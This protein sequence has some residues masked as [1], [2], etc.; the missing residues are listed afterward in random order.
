MTTGVDRGAAAGAV[1]AQAPEL[2]L[3]DRRAFVGFPPIIF[4]P[5]V[6]IADFA[7]Q[8]PEVTFPFSVTG[9]AL[10]YQRRKLHFGFLEVLIDAEVISR[11]VAQL[12]AKLLEL[13]EVKLHFRAGYL[14]GEARLST[15]NRAALTFKVAFDA[16][17]EMLAVHIYDV[18]FY[19]FAP[20]PSS[21]VPVLISQAV[22]NLDLL[23][24][25]EPRG[26]IGFRTRVLPPLVQFAAVSR[27]YK[28]PVLEQARL[29][30]VEISGK[31]VRL[32]FSAGGISA[33]AVPDEDLLLT[34]EGARAFA[35]AEELIANGS[36]AE[37]REAYLKRGDLQEAHP[38]AAERLLSLLVADPQ[39]HDLALDVA[40]SLGARRKRSAAALWAEA[41]VREHRGENARAAERYLALCA[42]SRKQG[43]ETSAFFAAEAAAR[44]AQDFAPQLAVK[45]LHELL[46]VKP[47]H[48][49]SLQ[50]LARAADLALDRAGAIRAYRRISA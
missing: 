23:P 38:F 28:I 27:G 4:A 45:A 30:A 29:S 24:E 46:G 50:A 47:D 9:G 35:D 12:A 21:Q 7:L 15:G 17:A 14:E 13:E 49:P 32:R 25:V 37:A 2:R 42:L 8:I 40:L 33:P 5:G 19:G 44:S 41:V 10:R 3:L 6:V 26:A 43:D 20:T 31:G 11:R 36:L 1:K 16:D 22:A 34:L 39:A 18:R 48:L